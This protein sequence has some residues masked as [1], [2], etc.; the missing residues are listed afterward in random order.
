MTCI[1]TG[2]H[3]FASPHGLWLYGDAFVFGEDALEGKEGWL[4]LR[5]CEVQN[6]PIQSVK[7]FTIHGWETWFDELKTSMERNSTM[8]IPPHRYVYHG[9]DG[10][11]N[12]LETLRRYAFAQLR[13][14]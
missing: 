10:T 11:A 1:K 12:N 8:L 14:S 7:H 5:I 4:L 9:Y 3:A 2:F 13:R 6:E